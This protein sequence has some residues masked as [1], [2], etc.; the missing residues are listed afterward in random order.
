METVDAE[1]ITG[2]LKRLVYG[3]IFHTTARNLD[4]VLAIGA[5]TGDW[6]W[7]LVPS[8]IKI[9]PFAYFLPEPYLADTSPNKARQDG[10]F[11]FLFVGSLIPRKRVDLLLDALAFLADQEFELNIVGD[12]EMYTTL[13][14]KAEELL[15]GRVTFH[16][17]QPINEIG[18]W[19]AM[20]DCLVLPSRHDGWGAVISE[21][22]LSGSAVV[23]SSACGARDIV[24]A[25]ARGAVFESGDV[26]ALRTRLGLELERGPVT[27]DERRLLRDW[28]RCAG[29]MRGAEYL[30]AL[31]VDKNSRTI[32]PP[33]VPGMNCTLPDPSSDGQQ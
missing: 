3:W 10:P 29:S 4:G 5:S 24:K 28:G 13:K 31:L 21:A 18:R 8:T 30:E 32:D 14:A 22:I 2:K 17:T 19:M 26:H 27:S 20:S 33:W 15:P 23:C 12:G 6:L 25:S 7:P 1:G 9:H 16:G 11:R